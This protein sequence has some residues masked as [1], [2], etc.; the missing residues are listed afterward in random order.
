MAGNIVKHT[1]TGASGAQLSARLDMP[2]GRVE[3]YALFAHCFTCSKDLTASRKVAESLTAAG[4]AVLRFDFT[5]LGSSEG[6]FAST[7]FSLNLADLKSAA[8]YLRQN[9]EAPSLLV[10]H[11]LGGAAVIAVAAEIPEVKAVATIAAPA[12]ATHVT[13]NFAGKLAEIREKGEAKV[14]LGERPFTIKKQ[15]LDDLDQHNVE[16]SAASLDRALLILHSPIDT[17][18]GIDNARRLF[19]AARH[20]K[21]FCSLDQADH[22]LS[23]KRDAAYAATVISAWATRYIGTRDPMPE[24]QEEDG[25]VEL[26]E[27]GHGKF[28]NAVKVGPHGML[29]DEPTSVGGLGTGP[30]PYE[31]LSIALGACTNMTLRMYAD[32]KDIPLENVSIRVRHDRKHIDDCEHCT[33]EDREM[34]T[35]IDHFERELTFTGDLDEANRKRLLEIADKCPVHRTLEKGAKVLTKE[36]REA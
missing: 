25:Y 30:T 28:Q 7:N 32:H 27:T 2:A 4:I 17:T 3:A 19:D 16:K 13:E 15:F 35:H 11:S 21:S 8:D 26:T 6:D 24:E 34:G 9:Y 33:E 12:D 31:Y 20:P 1:F 10:G 5:G 14:S 36:V 29:A 23:D 22:L 18:V